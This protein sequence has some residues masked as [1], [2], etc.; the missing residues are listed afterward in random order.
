MINVDPTARPEMKAVCRIAKTMTM[1]FL[2]EARLR[3][4]EQEEKAAQDAQRDKENALAEARAQR[5]AA[6]AKALHRAQARAAQQELWRLRG[7]LEQDGDALVQKLQILNYETRFLGRTSPTNQLEESAVARVEA[8]WWKR[9][10]RER[11][12]ER[13]Y[14]VLPITLQPME[15]KTHRS[16]A[17]P[18]T[19]QWKDASALFSWL[20]G[21]LQKPFPPVH[22]LD[23][24]VGL[25]P[26]P[27]ANMLLLTLEQVGVEASLLKSS[28]PSLVTRGYGAPVLS[29]LNATADL[30]VEREG[31]SP[32]DVQYGEEVEE[33]IAEG[34]VIDMEADAPD[35]ASSSEEEEVAADSID[36][37]ERIDNGH[38]IIPR[39]EDPQLIARWRKETARLGPQLKQISQ[40]HLPDWRRNLQEN[41]QRL[42]WLLDAGEWRHPFDALSAEISARTSLIAGYEAELMRD[43]AAMAEEYK[44][45]LSRLHDTTALVEQRATGVSLA[46]EKLVFINDA[47][48]AMEQQLEERKDELSDHRA[49]AKIRKALEKIKQETNEMNLRIGLV[50]AQLHDAERDCVLADQDDDYADESF[51]DSSD[52]GV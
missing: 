13:L 29:L 1:N 33:H 35:E 44:S 18:N 31:W 51:D 36:N 15:L 8:W 3:M 34:D 20:L 38:D 23:S 40:V 46:A 9:W 5:K 37:S 50:Q 49:V 6:R 7:M 43:C 25:K 41:V 48:E 26:V 52:A 39:M 42:R 10:R 21:L 30:C 32:Q 4:R 19:W 14:F 12:F 24:D 27:L 22:V 16:K 47:C 17:K 2:K 11:P 45:N 28:S